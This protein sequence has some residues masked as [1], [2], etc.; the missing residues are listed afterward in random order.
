MA[1]ADVLPMSRKTERFKANA[2]AAFASRISG[3]IETSPAWNPSLTLFFYFS[4][5][6]AR[7]GSNT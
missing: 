1:R 3:D 7:S 4:L 2:H 5:K 6:V